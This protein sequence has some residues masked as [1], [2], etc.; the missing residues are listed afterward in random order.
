MQTRDELAYAYALATTGYDSLDIRSAR[1][2]RCQTPVQ[3]RVVPSD[4]V[5]ERM[6]AEDVAGQFVGDG[7]GLHAGKCSV[8][9]A[10]PYMKE[11]LI[12]LV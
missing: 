9:I 5:A 1:Q 11:G 8:S 12:D 4:S 10:I 7:A 2:Q 3:K 6:E